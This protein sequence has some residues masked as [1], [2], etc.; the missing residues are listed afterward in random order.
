TGLSWLWLYLIDGFESPAD[1]AA[2][3]AVTLAAEYLVMWGLWRL[4]RRGY[5]ARLA[6]VRAERDRLGA[7]RDERDL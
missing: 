4:A 5:A 7:E 3:I 2:Y 1:S 6:W